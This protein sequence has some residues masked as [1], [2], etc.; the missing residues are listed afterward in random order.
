M[1]NVINSSAVDGRSQTSVGKQSDLITT[2]NAWSYT[3]TPPYIFMT[4]YVVEH[5]DN[6]TF[7]FTTTS[8]FTKDS[9]T[10]PGTLSSVITS[11]IIKCSLL[12][13]HRCKCKMLTW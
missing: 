4:W 3:S 6:F 12:P 2:L 1:I 10:I 7:T 5:R 13:F 9:H 8:K 11:L